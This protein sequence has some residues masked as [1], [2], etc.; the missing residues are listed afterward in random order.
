MNKTLMNKKRED[1]S[2]ERFKSGFEALYKETINVKNYNDFIKL[3]WES[4]DVNERTNRE[5]WY[6][7]DKLVCEMCDGWMKLHAWIWNDEIDEEDEYGY[8]NSN[9]EN[10]EEIISYPTSPYPFKGRRKFMT[11]DKEY[12]LGL[13]F[14]FYHDLDG[15]IEEIKQTFED[16]N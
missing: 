11:R 10:P 6:E 15:A 4:K 1:I 12:V 13:F 5:Y 9:V 2:W 3:Y 16:Y 8:K 14:K 7:S